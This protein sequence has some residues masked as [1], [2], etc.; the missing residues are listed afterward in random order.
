MEL[1]RRDTSSTFILLQ[2][3]LTLRSVAMRSQWVES[4]DFKKQVVWGKVT[5]VW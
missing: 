2:F 1:E 4:R 3:R 5:T